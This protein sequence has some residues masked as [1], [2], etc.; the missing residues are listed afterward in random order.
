M[1]GL[2]KTHPKVK[3]WQ[4]YQRWYR[5][6]LTFKKIEYFFKS[7]KRPPQV[8]YFIDSTGKREFYPNVD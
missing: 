3:S 1:N 4:S 5:F 6:E 2:M 7:Y 8:W